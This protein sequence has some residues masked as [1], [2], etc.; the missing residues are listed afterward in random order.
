MGK[1]GN[2]RKRERVKRQRSKRANTN[3]I[4]SKRIQSQSSTHGS[5]RGIR[6][7]GNGF[8]GCYAAARD[9]E[10]EGVDELVLWGLD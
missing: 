2:G 6:R 8:V 5:R 3:H 10:E 4:R 9:L 7:V 1:W